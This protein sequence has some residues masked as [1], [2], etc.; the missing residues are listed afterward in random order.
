MKNIFYSA[1][2][3]LAVIIVSCG[4]NKEQAK[5][6]TSEDS[7]RKIDSITKVLVGTWSKGNGRS[8]SITK[9]G[10]LFTVH[11]STKDEGDKEAAYTLDGQILK[12]VDSND[13]PVS[14]VEDGKL[15]FKGSSYTKGGN[16]NSADNS[17]DAKKSSHSKNSSSSN[18]SKSSTVSSSEPETTTAQ[19]PAATELTIICDHTINLFNWPSTS[20]N[21]IQGLANGQVCKLIKR[22]KQEAMSGKTD[23]WYEVNIDGSKGWVF[24]AYTSLKLQ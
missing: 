15:L 19:T 11:Y 20:A 18:K 10:K 9:T 23:Y 14:L 22:G 13:P 3:G 17:T 16:D 8:I 7:I 2:I 12:P 6:N 1:L 5:K 21:V 4:S 24:G